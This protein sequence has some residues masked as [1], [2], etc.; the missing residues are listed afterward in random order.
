MYSLYVIHNIY[1]IIYVTIVTNERI[2]LDIRHVVTRLLV[3]R[4]LITITDVRTF[5]NLNT[6][7]IK[8]VRCMVEDLRLDI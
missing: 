3:T 5:R 4:L 7:E 6:I 1:V 2:S 8:Y